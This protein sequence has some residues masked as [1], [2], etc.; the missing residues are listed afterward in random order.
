MGDCGPDVEHRLQIVSSRV[1]KQCALPAY[2]SLNNIV[3]GWSGGRATRVYQLGALSLQDS[4][5]GPMFETENV[6]GFFIQISE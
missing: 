2:R 4:N 6:S 1:D 3:K 5:C